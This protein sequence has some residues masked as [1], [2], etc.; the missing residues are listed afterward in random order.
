MKKAMFLG[1]AAL[2]ALALFSCDNTSV[3]GDINIPATEGITLGVNNSAGRALSGTTAQ[4][5]TDL[6]EAVFV[7]AS[8]AIIRATW[9]YAQKG[10]IQIEPGTY[11]VVIM[12]GRN[13]D[14]TLLGAGTV[15]SITGGGSVTPATLSVTI[16]S[17]TTAINFDVYPLLNNITSTGTS[18]L[19]QGETD[20]TLPLTDE[21]GTSNSTFTTAL[22]NLTVKYPLPLTKDTLGNNVPIFM[23]NKGGA[24]AATWKFDIGTVSQLATLGPQIKVASTSNG[25]PTIFLTGYSVPGSLDVP[26]LVTTSYTGPAAGAVLTTGTISFSIT[27][28]NTDGMVQ[29]ALEVPVVAVGDTAAGDNPVVWYIR[30]GLNNGLIDAGTGTLPAP[31]GVLGGAIVLG[32]GNLSSFP[33][34]SL[35]PNTPW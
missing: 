24:T 23:I 21:P 18:G 8:S 30:G 27:A 35:I 3:P 15:E 32:F 34:V 20:G 22:S 5:G 11:T 4:P 7:N 16:A 2:L 1:F 13:S 28:P 26:K 25:T 29:I 9:N 19:Y 10:K 6:Y 14:K 31:S 33:T 12:A 17:T